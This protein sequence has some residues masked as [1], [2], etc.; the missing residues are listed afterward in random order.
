V[1]GAE[2]VEWLTQHEKLPMDEVIALMKEAQEDGY[3]TIESGVKQKGGFRYTYDVYAEKN[4]DG[5]WSFG[6]EPTQ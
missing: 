3:V 4:I 5:A 1:N 2:L 6:V